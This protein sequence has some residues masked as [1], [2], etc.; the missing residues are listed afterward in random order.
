MVRGPLGRSLQHLV[1]FLDEIHGSR[2]D[3]YLHQ[4]GIDTSTAAGKALFQ[5]CGVFAEFERA[6]IQERVKAGLARAKAS[7]K[8]LGRPKVSAEIE[9]QIRAL[10]ASGKGMISIARALSVGG[11]TVQRVLSEAA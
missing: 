7:G 4:Q 10:R 9:E 1:G 2:I 11:G 5:M 6:M 8:T 3:L